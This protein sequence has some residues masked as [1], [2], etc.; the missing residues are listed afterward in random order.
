MSKKGKALTKTFEGYKD[1]TYKDHLGNL[2]CGWGHHLSEGSKVCKQINQV[3]FKGDYE[4]AVRTYDSY[5]FEID[6]IRR[7]AIVDM[8]FNLGASRFATF[9]KL[10]SALYEKDYELAGHEIKDSLYYHQVMFRAQTI[11]EIIIEGTYP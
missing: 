3:F 11:R 5:N 10:I 7:D 2:T 1:V 9:R 8:I 6:Y 4:G